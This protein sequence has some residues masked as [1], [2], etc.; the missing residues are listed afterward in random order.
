MP[1]SRLVIPSQ[2]PVQATGLPYP[3]GQLFFYLTGTSTLTP[4]Y[5]DSALTIP[6]KNPVILDSAG[7]AGN[8]F[9]DPSV[10]YKIVLEDAS[11]DLIWTFDPVSPFALSSIQGFNIVGVSTGVANAQVVS[12]PSTVQNGQVLVVT[13][14]FTNTGPMTLNSNGTAY[15]VYQSGIGGPQ[16]LAGGEVQVGVTYLFIFEQTLNSD[17][18][19]WQLGSASSLGGLGVVPAVESA[20]LQSTAPAAFAALAG[21]VGAGIPPPLGRL[22]LA[23]NTPVMTSNVLAATTLLYT[24]Y[25]GTHA[26]FWNGANWEPGAFSELSVSL[27]DT[28][29]SPAAAVAA[30]NYDVFLWQSAPGVWRL[31]RGPVWTNQTTRSAGTYLTRQQGFLVNA[32]AIMNGPALGYGLF[33]GSIATDAAGATVSWS[34]GGSG[35]G[36]VAGLLDIWNMY[37]RPNC[38]AV[39]MDTGSPYTYTSA[40]VRQARGNAKNQVSVL[41]GLPED[42]ISVAAS[43]GVTTYAATGATVSIGFGVGSKTTYATPPAIFEAIYLAT[44]A[45]GTSASVLQPST[46][47]AV[48]TRNEN[49]DGSNA[50]TFDANSNDLLS[51]SMRM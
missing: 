14:G 7:D 9:L 49:S 16:A 42:A 25:L 22:T 46:G 4:T 18:G 35:S 48:I 41:V 40:T 1:G 17:N 15:P 29:Y 28:T 21:G 47:L 19:G 31:S 33:L 26:P 24:P 10:V 43:V 44:N 3:G 34:I 38:C 23:S 8:V 51:V 20:L 45:G 6:N 32:A 12:G 37:N 39:S 50:N 30:S 27:S 13:A 36:G 2:Q 11:G 5:S